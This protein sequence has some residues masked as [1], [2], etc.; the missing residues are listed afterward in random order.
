VV[1]GLELWQW[2]QD[3]CKSAVEAGV[4]TAEV[5]WLLQEV[6]TLDLLALRLESFKRRSQIELRYSL[7]VLSQL[8]HQRLHDRRPIQYLAGVTPWRHFSLTVSPAVLIPRPE[9][10]YLIDLAVDAVRTK[11]NDESL[12][13]AGS[14]LQPASLQLEKGNWVDLGTGSGAIAIGLAEA[15]KTAT[16]HAALLP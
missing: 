5:D 3:A 10:E 6:A 7:P 13:V 15:F 14:N 9:T 12:K 4:P 2:R 16:I 8:W 1:S 11:L